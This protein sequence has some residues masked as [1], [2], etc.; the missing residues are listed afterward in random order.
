[1][2]IV[3]AAFGTRGDVQPMVAL[4]VRLR[5]DG[6]QV[7]IGASEGF[8]DWVR[9]HGLGFHT[10]GRDIESWIR[11]HGDLVRRPARVLKPVVDYLRED[12]DLS[13]AQLDTAAR[14]A[15]LLVSG[16]HAAAPSVAEANGVP[17]RTL[18]F[19]P[20]MLRSRHHPPPCIPW[21]SLPAPV[22]ALL[23]WACDGGFD[24]VFKDA[25]NRG[26]REYG[27]SPIAKVVDYL[28]TDRPIVASDALLGELPPDVSPSIVQTGALSLADE[29]ALDPALERFL[30]GGAPPVYIG[31]G[32]MPDNDPRHTTRTLVEALVACGRR[33]VIH[34][35]WAGLGEG[36]VPS[37]VCVV[38][39]APHA[40]LLPRVALA[41]HHGGAGTT[42]AAARAGVPQ[43][44]V[45][46]AV[47]QYYWGHQVYRCGL[48]SR[49]IP[50]RALTAAKLA[51]A[52]GEVLSQPEIAT[53]ARE[54]KWGLERTDG[55]AALR[56]LLDELIPD[57]SG[58]RAAA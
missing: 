35:G 28:L 52:I 36:G 34:S 45:P 3:L 54:I 12:V 47:D 41:V 38:R 43:I 53:R 33:S 2:K 24:A 46:H 7:V 51:R 30:E 25:I 4:G 13:F 22:N 55:V 56:Q 37:S 29:S 40:W 32:S 44:V 14:G 18:L 9:D 31:F 19:C 57:S 8:A 17:Y 5:A 48:G 11:T 10:V 23:W 26:R 6:H 49:P 21:F 16:L 20:Q 39:S 1:M 50:R 27:L 15:D 42:A 58:R